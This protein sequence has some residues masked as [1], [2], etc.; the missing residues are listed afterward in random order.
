MLPRTLIPDRP[1]NTKHDDCERTS[2][3]TG[4]HG[5]RR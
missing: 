5:A 3:H 1:L 4:A 2:S